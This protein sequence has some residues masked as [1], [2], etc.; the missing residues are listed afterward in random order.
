MWRSTAG[1]CL[2]RWDPMR[3]AVLDNLVL[4]TLDEADEH[5][6]FMNGEGSEGLVRM[7][8]IEPD[9]ARFVEDKFDRVRREVSV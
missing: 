6:T 8:E 4:F 1:L 2:T 9:F 3:P 7:R 5:D